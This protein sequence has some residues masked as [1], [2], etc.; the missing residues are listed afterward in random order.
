[1]KQADQYNLLLLKYTG[2]AQGSVSAVHLILGGEGHYGELW[3]KTCSPMELSIR[4]P[5]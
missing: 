5:G 2:M 3:W 4:L 1:M